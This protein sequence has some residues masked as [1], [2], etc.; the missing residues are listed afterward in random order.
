MNDAAPPS[1]SAR[2]RRRGLLRRCAGVA[3]AALTG[4]L[5]V[6]L[7][8]VAVAAILLTGGR[9]LP[10]PGP[11]VAR[12]EAEANAALAGAAA[13][14]LGGAR[15]WIEAGWRPGLRLVDAELLGPDGAP[16]AVLPDLRA[17]FDLAALRAGDLIP[18]TLRVDGAA[19]TAL[20]DVD[21]SFVF[22][23]AGGGGGLPRIASL[24][25][26]LKAVDGIFALPALAG[27]ETVDMTALSV[28]LDD[29]RAGRTWRFDGGGLHLENRADA[30]A[31]DLSLALPPRPDDPRPDNPAAAPARAALSFVSRRGSLQ[32][33]V[34]AEIA[35]LAST[36]IAAQDPGLGWLAALDAPIDGQFSGSVDATGRLGA[37]HADLALGPGALRTLPGTP[38]VR[39]RAASLGLDFDPESERITLSELRVD[40]PQMRFSG[41]GKI[42]P[43]QPG[44]MG[45]GALPS[46][47]LV[48]LRLNDVAVDPEGLFEAP[49]RFEAGIADLRLGVAPLRVD[50]GQVQLLDGDRRLSLSGQ[51]RT[52]EG[53]WH[54]ALDAGLN[55]MEAARLLRLWP[56]TLAA[57]TRAWAAGNLI[58]GEIA[59][60]SAALRLVPGQAP[61]IAANFAFSGVSVR[62]LRTLPPVTGAR[63][64]AALG[65]GAFSV[66]VL[67]GQVRAPQGGTVA[68]AGSSFRVPDITARP[69]TGAVRLAVSGPVAAMLSLLDEP[70]FR[71]LTRAGRPVALAEGHAEG[72]AE[73]TL[74]LIRRP[75]PDQIAFS[76]T[77]E[78]TGATSEVLVPGRRLE[79]PRVAVT[80][81]PAQ[82]TAS[83][84]GTLSGVP[85]AAT[86][87]QPLTPRGTPPA[88]GRVTGEIE[89]S[90]RFAEAFGIGLPAG[91][92]SGAAS[93]R[94]TLS[95][96][97]GTAP[98]FTL[99]S[100]LAGLGLRLPE[101]AWS[102]AAAAGGR[103]DVAGALERPVRI[104]RLTLAAPGLDADG[105]V[106]LTP[107]GQLAELAFANVR[108][109]GWLSAP[110]RLTPAGDG[111][112][113]VAIGGGELSLAA[114][115]EGLSGGGGGGGGSGGGTPIE[116]ALDR[117][118]VSEGIALTGFRGRFSTAGGFSGQFSARINGAAP[119]QGTLAP[120]ASGRTA[121]RLRA[122]DAGA[123]LAAA[124]IVRTA[125]GGS[126]DL[127]MQPAAAPGTWN[128]RLSIADTRVVDAP[129]LAALLNAISVVGLIER[130]GGEGLAF[131]DVQASFR[132][133]PDTVTITDGSAVGASLGVSMAGTYGLRS[134]R[135]AFQG[136]FSP[137]YMLNGI[138]AL[139]TRRGEGLF[140]FNYAVN[141]TADAPQV[142]V[143]PLSI[144]TPSMF[145]DLF[146]RTPPEITE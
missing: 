82:V 136:V 46:A 99:A 81:D 73:V 74:P 128:G 14:R 28:T 86:W 89:L 29:V 30:V 131:S 107:E 63:G 129:I 91:M 127:V 13:V 80:A 50:I 42:Y 22:L 35:G 142:S 77:A 32:A 44:V 75:A 18:R 101:V 119:V 17:T 112:L 126:F 55:R 26:F 93:G 58:A 8:L 61:V 62:A 69:A 5:A 100:D 132:L 140:G 40:S 90:P 109:G 7:V 65:D 66:T 16:A 67:E 52:G 96:A 98:G 27:V 85:F 84:A 34:R 133:T 76:A 95:L 110:V 88:P 135:I 56:T 72:L 15:L 64:V 41:T 106:R 23:F 6:A 36:D 19:V 12:I 134:R 103:L 144:L 143:N 121:L 145:R 49:L 53:G 111:R 78:V 9:S 10:V 31:F 25:D 20:R 3:S 116:V 1:A 125:R 124:G 57:R 59:D 97:R 38:P 92:L 60:A 48:Q 21:G 4:A 141:G 115:P 70:P 105:R 146:R 68:L 114:L 120:A 71:F 79:A 113:A 43:E 39:F 87:S 51:A 130:L 117:V 118:Q 104:D 137:V 83:G 37:V 24:A 123:T 54:V 94:F 11:V 138:G 45:A 139:L 2:P 47:F 122:E 102:K 33:E 108:L